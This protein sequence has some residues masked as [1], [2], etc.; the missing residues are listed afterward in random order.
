MEHH[1]MSQLL[2]YLGYSLRNLWRS[3][4]WSAFAIFSVA[5]GVATMVAFRSLGLSIGDS[6]VGDV[7][8]SNKGDITVSVRG[9]NFSSTLGDPDNPEYFFTEQDLAIVDEWAAQNHAQTT[10]Y[11]LRSGLQVAKL[12]AVTVGRL[13]FISSFFIDPDDYPV[14]DPILAEDPPNV[15][16]GALFTDPTDI[17]ISR[18]MADSAQIHVGDTVRVSGSETLFTV[19]GIVPTASQ[20]GLQQLF[21][22]E[23]FSLFFG[24]TYFDRSAV[25]EFL[26]TAGE[27][28]RIGIIL[29]DGSSA[30]DIYRLSSDLETR[31]ESPSNRNRFNF[32]EAPSLA[33][34][35]STISDYLG[36]FIVILGLGAM[37]LGGVGII[38]TML[39]LVRRRTDEIA[40]L[41][42][43][44]LKG[45]Q[46]ATMF[47]AE[48]FWLGIFGSLLGSVLG[49]AL[50]SVANRFGADLIQQPLKFKVYPEAI[51]FGLGLGILIAMVFGVLPVLSAA[52]VR[53]ASILRPNDSTPVNAGC[54]SSVFVVIFIVLALG[55][56]AGQII[57]VW[58]VGVV[59]VAITLLILYILAM[60][61]WCVV[62][63]LGKLPAFGNV[64]LNLALRNL[65]TR[66]M[67]TATTLLAL[68][69]GMFALS[70][71]ALFGEGA[72]EILRFTFS[73]SLGGNIVIFPL[74]PQQIATPIIDARLNTMEGIESRTRISSINAYV[75]AVNGE[76]VFDDRRRFDPSSNI[77]VRDTTDETYTISGISA[78]RSLTPADRGQPVAVFL[79]PQFSDPTEEEAPIIYQVGDKV[80][81]SL[82]SGDSTI[83]VE[84]VGV[85][86]A[87]AMIGLGGFVLPPDVIPSADADFTLNL[88]KASPEK[89]NNVLLGLSS[90]PL[91]LTFDISFFDGIL[92][93]LITQFSA[94]PLVVGLFSL[95]AAA[96]I[97]ANTVALSILERRRQ[98]GVLRAVGLQNGRVLRVLI[99]ENVIVCLLGGV[100]GIGLSALGVFIMTRYG[101]DAAILIPASA[102]PTAVGLILISVLIGV[103]ATLA[104]GAVAV[105]ERITNT[106]RYE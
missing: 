101:L 82:F 91:V 62:W 11:Q 18:N 8:N 60:L 43:F 29:P 79:I 96:V 64:D 105:R 33:S 92:Q 34:S 42:T 31:L 65:T 103:L 89:L 98:I 20:A 57:T 52:R 59:G 99:L 75:S 9:D 6:L 12:D 58:W 16:L 17:V 19:K 77:T 25:H 32:T 27:A 84:V 56:I 23:V 14:T 45:W 68:S 51:L 41:K 44:G 38:N 53:P 85:A 13:Q 90:I 1:A 71:I 5:A 35:F 36:R 74:L 55:L 104:S 22:R 2:F 94:L 100:I 15:P 69:A 88:I 70:S 81:L 80:A 76:R 28:N 39:V 24:F 63:L 86:G 93:R 4:R 49:V 83:T 21:S 40:A 54:F 3:R 50:S 95:G 67:R 10:A 66:R 87:S 26:N 30:D 47:L 37:L 72:R 73:D 78:G 7:R 102:M 106:L 61:L 97:N 46:V 48:A